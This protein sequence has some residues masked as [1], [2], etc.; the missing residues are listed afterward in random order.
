MEEIKRIR[1]MT[2]VI[3][4]YKKTNIDPVPYFCAFPRRGLAIVK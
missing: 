1:G 3:S 4:V 2:D